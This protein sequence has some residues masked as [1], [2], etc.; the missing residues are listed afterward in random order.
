MKTA[1]LLLVCCLGLAGV[2]SAQSVALT[3]M[4]GRKALVIVDG[5]PPKS[6]AVGETHRGVRI[7]STEGDTAVVEISG[8]RHT[9]RVGESPA[10]VGGQ[11]AGAGGSK[12]VLTA[13]GGGHFL[14]MGQI[15]GRAT[16]FV[17]DTGATFV[18]MSVQ[19]AELAKIN[20][21]AGQRVSMSTANGVVPGW[22]VKLNSVRVGD[23]MVYDV[24]AVVS[25]GAMPYVL[26]GNSFLTRFQMTRTNDQMVLEKRY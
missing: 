17:V 24:D 21:Q 1:P 3:G 7:V 6:L 22:R 20:Y 2:A 12:I 4:L 11:P 26:L 15:N 9:L 10:S 5:S 13:G 16:Q 25:A 18:S 14:T 8:L 19:D 23:V